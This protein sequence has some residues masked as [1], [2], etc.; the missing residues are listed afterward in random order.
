MSSDGPSSKPATTQACEQR[1]VEYRLLG[2][3]EEAKD[4]E[5]KALAAGILAGHS[6][7]EARVAITE[8]D[9]RRYE[10]P[11]Y[12]VFATAMHGAITDINVRPAWPSTTGKELADRLEQQL[13]EWKVPLG[14]KERET[15]EELRKMG[16]ELPG[17]APG[18]WAYRYP[19]PGDVVLRVRIQGTSGK[20]WFAVFEFGVPVGKRPE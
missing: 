6:L 17:F 4:L 5:W 11:V 2:R 16:S 13:T 8:P 20:G 7:R 10:L 15:F 3:Q 12:N 1:V 9:G 18:M 19:L 14:E